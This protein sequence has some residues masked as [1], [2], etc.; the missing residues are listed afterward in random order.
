MA[1]KV[2]RDV[3]R[4]V[5][6]ADQGRRGHGRRVYTVDRD[7]DDDDDDIRITVVRRGE[8]GEL[9]AR[10]RYETQGRRRAK[11]QSMFLKPI[12]RTM[13][14]A[15]KRQSRMLDDYLRRHE[16][17]NAERRNGW[18]RDLPENLIRSMRRTRSG[19]VFKLSN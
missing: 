8:R 5:V 2:D 18:I 10:E 17:S 3:R 15:I 7:D 16:R 14:R 13:R 9:I 6:V 19:R 4:V 1:I 12:E 11:K